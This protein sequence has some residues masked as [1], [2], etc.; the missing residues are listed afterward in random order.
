MPILE[1]ENFKSVVW[2][3]TL[4]REVFKKQ[5]KVRIIEEIIKTEKEI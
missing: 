1:K 3:S 2:T 5:I 4:R